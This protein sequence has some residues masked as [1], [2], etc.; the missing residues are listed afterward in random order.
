MV[1]ALEILDASPAFRQIPGF[2]RLERI[3]VIV[4]N[5]HNAPRTDWDQRE[6]PPG[7]VA[8]LV[9]SSGVPIDR[10]SYESVQLMRD[11]VE[12]WEM[13]RQ[14]SVAR[15]RLNG[16]TAVNANG[17]T[18]KVALLLIDVSFD[19]I[20]DPDERRYFMNLP[21][22]SC[23]RRKRSTACARWRD[24][25]SSHRPTISNCCRNSANHSAQTRR[26]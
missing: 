24:S 10:Y 6:S 17:R 5:A 22:A 11:T 23:S 8:Q 12:R 19:Y 14:L 20:A 21:T 9:Q 4:V 7:A 3:A 1:E 26:S 13:Q 15:R 16:A 18:H 2:D 25:F